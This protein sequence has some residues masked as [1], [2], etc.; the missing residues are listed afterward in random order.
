MK[1][2]KVE[3]LRESMKQA[4]PQ[5]LMTFCVALN[6]MYRK[7]VVDGEVPLYPAPARAL[8]E[9]IKEARKAGLK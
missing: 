3:H 2:T 5:E 4:T 1:Q 8:Q 6:K 9:A 7:M